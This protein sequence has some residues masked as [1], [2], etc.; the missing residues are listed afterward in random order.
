[1]AHNERTVSQRPDGSWADKRDGT[2]RAAS[3]HDTQAE[4]VTSA[5]Q[6]LIN[7]GGGEL[8]IANE[9]DKIRTKTQLGNDPFP[10]KD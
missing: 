9:Q 5:H 1:M 6:H 4:A 7:H 8:E 3:L 2:S 10:P